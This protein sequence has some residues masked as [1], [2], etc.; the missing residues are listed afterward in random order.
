MITID[1]F[2]NDSFSVQLKIKMGAKKYVTLNVISLMVDL[3]F[4]KVPSDAF[5]DR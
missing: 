2:R 1:A 5:L 3:Q 4:T